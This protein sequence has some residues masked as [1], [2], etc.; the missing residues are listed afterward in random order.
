MRLPSAKMGQDSEWSIL[1]EIIS[2]LIVLIE[3]SF[4]QPDG[5]VQ[6]AVSCLSLKFLERSQLEIYI[7]EFGSI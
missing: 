4:W 7:W 3:T 5:D 6:W 2:V 1:G